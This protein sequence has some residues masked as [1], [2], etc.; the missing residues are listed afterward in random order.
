MTEPLASQKLRGSPSNGNASAILG[1]RHPRLLLLAM[2]TEHQH[3]PAAS[4]ERALVT[5]QSLAIVE[6]KHAAYGD[7][8]HAL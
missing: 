4:H 8:K 5:V 1:I 3:C 2:R 6:R 7:W